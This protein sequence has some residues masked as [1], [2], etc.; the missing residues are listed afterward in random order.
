MSLWMRTNGSHAITGVQ[1]TVLVTANVIYY[2]HVLD[3]RRLKQYARN[4]VTKVLTFST[5]IYVLTY[6]IVCI[7]PV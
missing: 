1:F 4:T 7:K 2:Y 5:S 3:V 6:C